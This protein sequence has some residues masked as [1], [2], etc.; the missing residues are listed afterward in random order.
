MCPPSRK[1]RAADGSHRGAAVGP[2]AFEQA[3]AEALPFKDASFDAARDPRPLCAAAEVGDAV[4]LSRL[5]ALPG[6]AA[7]EPASF[8]S[9]VALHHPPEDPVFIIC[10]PRQV[11]E[12]GSFVVGG[13]H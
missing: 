11:V 8:G 5:L 10:H 12:A 1:A 7:A 13:A 2:V 4:V 3:K 9:A 6:T